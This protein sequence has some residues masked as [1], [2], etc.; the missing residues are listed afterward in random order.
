MKTT[1][2]SYSQPFQARFS[3]CDPQKILFFSKYFDWAHDAIE[4]RLA[5]DLKLR[6]LWFENKKWA[7]PLRHVEADYFAPLPLGEKCECIVHLSQ[8]G[9]SSMSFECHF[10]NYKSQ[11]LL[12][13]VKTVHVFVDQKRFQPIKV[14]KEILRFF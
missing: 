8:V 1:Q 5:A 7:V 12:A 2:L 9:K 14:P 6:R 13:V 10:V 11:K 4:G 3:D